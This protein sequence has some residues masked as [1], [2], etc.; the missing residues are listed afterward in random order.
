MVTT[1]FYRK[2]T[3]RAGAVQQKTLRSLVSVG[4]VRN[5]GRYGRS[6]RKTYFSS[7]FLRLLSI[8]FRLLDPKRASR[9]EFRTF[10]IKTGSYHFQFWTVNILVV[11]RPIFAYKY[12]HLQRDGTVQPLKGHDLSYKNSHL[13]PNRTQITSS[14]S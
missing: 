14:F 10:L 13:A 2:K 12:R 8:R 6:A 7:H 5:S 1:S 3:A 11:Q 9:P 4:S